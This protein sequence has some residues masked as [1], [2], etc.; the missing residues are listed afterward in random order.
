MPLP[1]LSELPQLTALSLAWRRL[2]DVKPVLI[3][4]N[5][6]GLVCC[7]DQG[8]RW[9]QRL[10]DWPD[11]VCREGVPLQREAI[12]EL[13]A[14]LIFDCDCP[15]AELVLCLPMNAAA[16]CVVD[17]YGSEGSPGLLPQSLQAVDL[18]FDLAES[19]ITAS[20]AQDALA[21]VGVPRS[22]IQGWS[23]VADL[24]D[25]PL[26][27]V[28][29]L[30]TAAQRAL[31]Q[32]TQTWEGD[33]A[34]LVEEEKSLRLLLFRQGVPEVDHALEQ[35]DPLACQREVRACVAAWQALVD[36]PSALGWW[37]SVPTVQVDDW[38]PLVD[39]ERGE[40]CLNQP[41]P[42]WAEPSD[43]GAAGDVTGVLSPLQ[44]L[45]LL[46]LQQEER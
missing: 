35:L 5:N 27:R 31:H 33:M 29:W 34:W 44:Q 16:W 30:L 4:V 26:R 7:W 2:V 46:A 1:A 13:M 41:L 32:L 45:A 20:P 15:G 28:D 3:A 18:P 24:A 23:E 25:V 42:T 10:V 22:L 9:Q 40:C 17:G 14:D 6:T 8:G 38:M 11:G 21:V 12:G 37:L 39:E 36:T 19:F 43:Q